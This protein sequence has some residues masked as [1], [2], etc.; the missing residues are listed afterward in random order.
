M[1]KR[2]ANTDSKQDTSAPR[3]DAFTVREYQLSGE[4]RTEWLKV[5]TAFPHADGKGFNVVLH[6][7]PADGK[8]TL[9]VHEPKETAAG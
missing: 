3:L 1:S 8:L 7:I 6:A 4:T 2:A 5:G 9:R